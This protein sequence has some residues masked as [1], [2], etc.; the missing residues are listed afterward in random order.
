MEA[1]AKFKKTSGRTRRPWPFVL[2]ILDGWGVRPDKSNDDATRLAHTP[3]LNSL[4]HHYPSALLGASGVDVG[5]PKGQDGNSEAGHLNLGAG[6]IV[7][8]DAVFISRSIKDGTFFKNAAFLAAIEH[9]KKN[10]S[11]LHLMGLLSNYNSGHSSPDHFFALLKLVEQHK[12]NPVFIHFFTDGRDSPRHD[13]VK[14]LTEVRKRFRNGEVV[15]T[16]AGRYYAMDRKKDWVRTEKTFN[17]LT[18]GRGIAE[19]SA[20][21]ALRHAYNRD[22]SDEFVSPVVIV[23]KNKKPVGVISDNDA[24]IFFNLRSD[25]ARQLAKPFVQTRFEKENPNSFKRWKVLKNL[26]FVALTDFGPDLGRIHTAYPSRDLQGT[27]PMALASV[28]QL[29]V[30]ESEKFA[31]MTYFFNG[32]YD[33]PVAGESRLSIPSPHVASYDRTP[34]MSALK[35]TQQVVRALKAKRFDFIALNFANA[36]MVGHTGNLPACVK[37]MEVIDDCL[38]KIG[39]ATHQAGGMLMVTA[40]HGNVEETLNGKTGEV[41]TEHSLN[42]VR[43]LLYAQA[44]HGKSFGKRRGVLGD[45]APTILDLTGVAKPRDMTRHSLLPR[46]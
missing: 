27:L 11:S 43:C 5:L 41:D 37:A 14:F 22:E 17:L 45:V 13:A 46:S 31:H 1:A 15:S 36:D 16:L 21:V 34:A 19:Q 39:K 28:R 38:A 44:W 23:G 6:R 9:V 26:C 10:H 32:G 30:A 29:Y 18:R 25:R 35:I 7:E 33:H 2:A 40:D 12:I 20:E 8:Q 24:V 3:F 42:P 4:E